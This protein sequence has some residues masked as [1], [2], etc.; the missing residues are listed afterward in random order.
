MSPVILVLNKKYEGVWSFLLLG[1]CPSTV[2]THQNRTASTPAPLVALK[3]LTHSKADEQCF[4]TQQRNANLQV[5][6]FDG[7]CLLELS[8]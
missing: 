5:G 1:H 3:Q 4:K 7:T 2:K 8:I 6:V